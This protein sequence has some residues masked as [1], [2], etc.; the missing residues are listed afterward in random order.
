MAKVKTTNGSGYPGVSWHKGAGKWSAYVHVDGKRRYLG[1]FATAEAA[2]AAV[3][4]VKHSLPQPV[5]PSIEQEQPELLAIVQRLYE[6]HGV[7]ALAT[8]FLEKQTGALYHRLLA[9][10]LKQPVLLV[11]LGLSDVYDT[12]K[13]SSRKYRGSIKP[14]WTWE[15]AVE[16]AREIKEREG[17]LP[18][19]QWF[20]KN[21]LSS[22]VVAVHKSGRIWEDLRSAVGSFATCPYYES[23][24]GMRWRSRPEASLSNFLY[25]RGVEHKRGERYPD[26]Y[27]V[28]NNRSR[29]HF[30]LHFISQSGAWIDVEIWGDL[31]DYMTD[32]RYAATRAM[33]EAFNADNAN[34][35]G[36]Q[37]QE[38]LSDAR[39]GQLLAPFIGYIEPFRFDKPQ[40]HAIETAH[41]SNADELLE[42]CRMLAAQMPD[43][44]FPSEDWLRKRGKYI[45]RPGPQYSTLAGRVHEWLG[46]TRQVRRLLN[47]ESN[48]TIEWTPAGVIAAWRAFHNKHGMTPSQYKA[49]RNRLNLP[50]D[51]VAEANRI[52]AA[53]KRHGVRE[54]A[55]AGHNTRVKWTIE[56]VTAAWRNFVS[57]HGVIPSQCMSAIRRKTMPHETYDEATRIYGAARRLGILE[58]LKGGAT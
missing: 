12:W 8:P 30:D 52:Y 14:Q 54:V 21:G 35:L 17:D 40:D 55:R 6:E 29:G 44:V 49:A 22:L 36:L 53:A 31:P 1:L 28:Q 45:S 7:E 48:N 25:A 26:E 18:T 58:A 34:F 16:R 9:A 57:T 32:G 38:C 5:R 33:K 46:G 51:I 15:V 42:T 27:A 37:Y 23:R 47:Q 24:N 3:L 43:G 19:V 13:R 50:T 4:A 56:S 41:W 20:R 2:N 11:K 10:R 39:L